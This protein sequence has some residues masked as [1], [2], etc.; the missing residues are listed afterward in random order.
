MQTNAASALPDFKLASMS[1][2]L[3]LGR[4]NSE[5]ADVAVAKLDSRF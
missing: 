1:Y 4:H 2:L 5:A 3:V